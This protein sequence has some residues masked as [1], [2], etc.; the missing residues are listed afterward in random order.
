MIGDRLGMVAAFGLLEF[1]DVGHDGK[2]QAAV[3][4]ARGALHL[5][6]EHV[7][8]APSAL[9]NGTVTSQI[10]VAMPLAVR[11]AAVGLVPV[12][13]D[14]I[15]EGASDDLL[16]AIAGRHQPVVADGGDAVVGIERKQ[17]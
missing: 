4:V 12:R 11:R 3:L 6:D 17:H 16:A 8:V 5:E 10:A 9:M 7:I 14:E 13:I 2:R 1:G 15:G